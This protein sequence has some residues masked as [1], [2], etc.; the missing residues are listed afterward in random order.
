[1]HVYAF[2]SVCRGDIEPNSDIDLLAI[3]DGYDSRFNTD[4]YSVYSYKRIRELWGEGN[5]FAW[6]LALESRLLFSSDQNDFLKAL[7]NPQP[8]ANCLRDCEK[9]YALFLEART[10]ISRNPNSKVFDLSTMFLSIRNIASCFSLGVI[11]QPDF[12]RNV[13]RKLDGFRIGVSLS[14]YQTLER[15]RILCT[16]GHG[17]SI[18]PSEIEGVALELD[19]IESWME[20]LVKGVKAHERI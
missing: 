9:F 1:M 8:Y 14:T 16:R 6:H 5:P 15:A 11:K 13:A 12:S 3:T 19:D 4:N 10:S 7:G 20:T 17:S 18:T 2:G